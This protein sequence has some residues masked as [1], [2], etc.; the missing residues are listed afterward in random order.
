MRKDA[1]E[2]E[3]LLVFPIKELSSIS[4]EVYLCI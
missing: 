2:I 3:L 4:A 1:D